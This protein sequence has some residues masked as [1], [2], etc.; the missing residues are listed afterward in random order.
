[1]VFSRG[2]VISLGV[3]ALSATLLFLYFRNRMASVERKVDTMFDLIQS[4][5]SDRQQQ[6]VYQEA[7]MRQQNNAPSS[8]NTGAWSQETEQPERNLIDVSE[9]EDDS[10][11]E[12]D[13]EDSK[14]VSDNEED[15]E[16]R[17]KLVTS[18][19]D[20]DV[21]QA[22]EVK[23]VE[24]LENDENEPVIVDQAVQLEEVTLEEDTVSSGDL[25]NTSQSADNNNN[26]VDDSLEEDDSEDESD[27]N[28]DETQ[29]V[30]QDVEYSKLRVHE[31]KAIAEA[32]GLTNYKS[33]K[34]QPLIDLIKATE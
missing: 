24:V 32:K 2:L 20:I 3:S 31:L 9:N 18:D 29:D 16:E 11:G 27:D 6:M 12:Y 19:I 4:H 30:V 8:Q 25:Q 26:E 22:E 15:L 33:L 1:M 10:E 21:E 13:S 14:E 28:D 7:I 17:I 5:E 23:N 34:K